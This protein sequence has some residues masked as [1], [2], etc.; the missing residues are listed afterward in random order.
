MNDLRQ[1]SGLSALATS[2]L[3]VVSLAIAAPENVSAAP[4]APVAA[5]PTWLWSTAH[6][7]PKETT[8]QGSG[9][10]SIIEGHNGRLYI[11]TAKYGENAYLV[12]FDPA[13]GKMEVV[14]DAQK[15]IG[16]TA[17]GFA[18]QSKFH[19]RNNVGASGKIYLGT[20]QGY[21]QAGEDWK[22]YPGGYPMVYDPATRRT[23]VYPVP[24]A[25][26]GIIDIRPDESR[27]VA[28]ISTC[29][30]GR[31]AASGHFMILD[32]VK[33]TYR[34]LRDCK[35]NYA[36][37]VVDF[38]ERAY[39]P[40]TGGKIARYD[41]RSDRLEEL[42]QT[43]DGQPLAPNS[44]L[45]T[46]VLNWDISPDGRTM[47][48]VAMTD[49]QLYAYDLTAPGP[50]LPARKLGKLL[51]KPATDCRAMC[52]G[53]KGDVW[54]GVASGNLHAVSY[55]PGDAAPKDHGPLAVRNAAKVQLVGAD[56]NLPAAHYGFVKQ[57]DGAIT[58][59]YHIMGVCQA[60]DGRVYLT[61]LVPF[62]LHQITPGQPAP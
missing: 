34:D 14:V 37:I 42:E 48:C 47:Y 62:T 32:L 61:S 1:H 39:H 4:A 15:E 5:P 17:K 16:T 30:D 24:I 55:H 31:P 3:L 28:Y 33:G 2:L 25:H 59:R 35:T 19:T 22:Q 9:Y 41:P 21:P 26:Q 46:D 49:N 18:A 12:E 29:A 53:P 20:K 45:R 10:F 27:G 43:I 51:A 6:L 38:Q 13:S 54:M 60:R 23:R 40:I 50:A 7:I 52:V 56:G 58:P 57:P 44:L 11:G 8:N 36:F